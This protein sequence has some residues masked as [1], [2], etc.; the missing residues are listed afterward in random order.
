[1][2]DEALEEMACIEAIMGDDIY[3][4]P[5][6]PMVC[7]LRVTPS[8]DKNTEQAST[9]ALRVRFPNGYPT[10][11]AASVTIESI[12]NMD[13][14]FSTPTHSKP[15]PSSSDVTALYEVIRAITV[16]RQGEPCLFDVV[17]GVRE[18]LEANTLT[19]VVQTVK[20]ESNKDHIWH[21]PNL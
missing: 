20:A 18:W 6:N 5:S 4:D 10:C 19:P 13:H 11:S 1:M 12:S 14:L 17:T 16:N 2:S 8:V 3:I 9:V 21:H 7:L 15:L